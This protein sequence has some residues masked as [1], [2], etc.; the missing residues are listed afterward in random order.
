MAIR[1]FQIGLQFLRVVGRNRDLVG[2]GRL[3]KGRCKMHFCKAV[4]SESPEHNFLISF[5]PVNLQHSV[6]LAP[7]NTNDPPT[8]KRRVS[9]VQARVS[10]W[11]GLN[12]RQGIHRNSLG[13]LSP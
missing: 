9:G 8:L 13:V 7:P 1:Y 5:G 6:A 11:C 3:A 4:T 12:S 2:V 10:L